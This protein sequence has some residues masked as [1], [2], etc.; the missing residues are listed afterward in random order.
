MEAKSSKSQEV[1]E[2]YNNLQVQ[3]FSKLVFHTFIICTFRFSEVTE[4]YIWIKNVFKKTNIF[5]L[6]SLKENLFS[7]IQTH[8][9]GFVIVMPNY[10]VKASNVLLIHAVIYVLTVCVEKI[11]RH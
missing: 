4:T 2:K 1:N 5:H 6:Q 3:D 9:F 11:M 8:F 10:T 7:L